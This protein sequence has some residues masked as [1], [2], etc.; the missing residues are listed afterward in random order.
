MVGW[1]W[2][3]VRCFRCGLEF[4][5]NHRFCHYLR[6]FLAVQGMSALAAGV[7]LQVSLENL[8]ESSTWP[9]HCVLQYSVAASAGILLLSLYL[10]RGPTSM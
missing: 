8:C 3:A 4:R 5:D 7:I 1:A 10:I 2:L 9:L 6:V